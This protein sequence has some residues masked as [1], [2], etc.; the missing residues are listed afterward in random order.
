M[1]VPLKYLINFLRTLE[2][3]FF[4]YLGFRL[5]TFTNHRTAEEG[6]GHFFNSSQPLPLASQTLIH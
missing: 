4:F 6:G 5:R 1:A 3:P 2:M